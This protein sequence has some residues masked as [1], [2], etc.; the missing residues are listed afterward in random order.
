MKRV[1]SFSRTTMLTAAASL[2]VTLTVSAKTD[3]APIRFDNPP[4][5]GHFDWNLTSVFLDVRMDA[6]SQPGVAGP[7]SFRRVSPPS[8]TGVA[9]P[10]GFALSRFQ[11]KTLEGGAAG[12]G[13]FLAPI[14]F[15]TPIPTPAGPEVDGF[16][17]STFIFRTNADPGFPETTLPEGQ[18]VYLGFQLD[19]SGQIHYGWL[20]ATRIGIELDALAWAYETEPGVPIA[21]GVPEPGTLSLLALGSA[22]LMR[23]RKQRAGK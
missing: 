23:R 22:A 16:F 2:A 14:G 3:A 18:E 10:P 15:G 7:S 6:A 9:F 11:G 8:G 21:A 19:L 13:R 12:P 5:P 17:P 1:F 4:G 20:L